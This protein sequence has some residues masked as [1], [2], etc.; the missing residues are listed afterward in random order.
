MKSQSMKAFLVAAEKSFENKDYGS[1]LKYYLS[2]NEF[3]EDDSDMLYK[4]AESA[5]KFNA[6]NLAED[7]YQKILDKESG[8]QFPLA[9]FWLGDIKQR[10]GKY[11]EAIDL[12][13]IYLSEHEGDDEYFTTRAKKEIEACQWALDLISN[14]SEN[15]NIQHMDGDVNSPYSDF[16]G[17]KYKDEFYYSSMRF[18]KKKDSH[19]P[20][21]LI[22]KI[23]KF[24]DSLSIVADSIFDDDIQM[25]AHLC[26]NRNKTKAYFTICDY[27]DVAD[28]RCDLYSVDVKN[29]G[30]FGSPE[31]LP[32]FINDANATN[33]Q[34]NIG[35]NS[36]IKKD[37]LYFVSD[38]DG[39]KGKKD[40]YY[41]YI[42]QNG[43]Y[44]RPK[45]LAS[46]NT[47]EDDITPFYYT[48]TN[49]LYF[50]SNGFMNMGGYDIFASP[51]DQDDF[52][53][54]VHQGFPLNSSYDDIYYWR[55]ND[56]KTAYFSSNR[57]GALYLDPETE[58]CCYDIFKVDIKEL[59]IDLEVLT[60][61]K[62]T[63]E[64]LP[65]AEV[66]LYD[67]N[68][69]ELLDK[70][71]A[72]GTNKSNF[73]LISGRN[74]YVIATRL[75]YEPDTTR[76][77]TLGINKSGTITKKLYLTPKDL[78]LEV[79]TFDKSTMLELEGVEITLENL[80]DTSLQNIVVVNEKDN[81]F[82]FDIL[83][84]NN[85]KITANRKGYQ[86]VS[87]VLNTNNYAG[88]VIVKKLYLP[89]LLNAYLPLVVYFDNDRPDRRSLRKV[90]RRTYSETYK[91]YMK[92]RGYFVKNYTKGLTD[93]NEIEQATKVINDFFDFEVKGGKEKLN[94]FMSTLLTVLRNGHS[95][96]IQ[97]KG[98]ASPRADY[99]Y[100]LILANR[101]V[102]S[103][104]KELRKYENG[105][106]IPF[107]KN[108]K[109]KITDVS[110]GESLAPENISDDLKDERHSIYSVEASRER[111]VE[112]I[113]I[114]TDLK[115][116]Q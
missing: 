78:R 9:T 57:E 18:T 97:L 20:N 2:A 5:R 19:Y 93:K 79:L 11:D 116:E 34:P 94:L 89:D 64:E 21:R 73:K 50:S 83:R 32:D 10:L 33:T 14:A 62:K 24:Q 71:F 109:L 113:K 51:Y 88:D 82:N 68:T 6:Y 85:Y 35:Y 26:F 15:I 69:D 75:G 37:I 104:E 1:A 4:S 101:R 39:G 102:N 61:N 70:V 36:I 100:N 23:L 53:K 27:E 40:I 54:P 45:N 3:S 99:K 84:G 48:P 80:S 59:E 106:L 16:A 107:I 7:K 47:T 111:R 72:A 112:V 31:K 49:T 77:N 86:S 52:G 103:V 76:F 12:F 81:K 30:T 98:Y 74:Y 90:T 46:V 56:G 17:M 44:T 60:F 114:S 58:A 28:I 105:A 25:N 92:K 66:S 38:R 110:Y 63:K 8:E 42:D 13:K 65:G 43:N 115:N 41:C 67:A 91:N 95:V 87:V 29:D 22:S 55:S 108:K 96:T